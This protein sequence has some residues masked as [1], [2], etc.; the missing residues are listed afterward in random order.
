V[1]ISLVVLLGLKADY[2][3]SQSLVYDFGRSL[4]NKFKVLVVFVCV[5]VALKRL[6]NLNREKCIGRC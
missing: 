4:N 1:D 6:E 3:L 2:S 5:L